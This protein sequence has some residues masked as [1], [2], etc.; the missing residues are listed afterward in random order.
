MNIAHLEAHESLR[1]LVQMQIAAAEP[2]LIDW[3]NHA[4]TLGEVFPQELVS[5]TGTSASCHTWEPH[6]LVT[7]GQ[8]PT[9]PMGCRKRADL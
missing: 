7:T 1:E 4:M 5:P 2:G 9:I 8:G 3:P 6:I